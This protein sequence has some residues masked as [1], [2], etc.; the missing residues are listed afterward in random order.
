MISG[1]IA[2]NTTSYKSEWGHS[3]LGDLFAYWLTVP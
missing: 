3:I 1:S 2:V